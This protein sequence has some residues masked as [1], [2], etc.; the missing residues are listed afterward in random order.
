MLS[1]KPLLTGNGLSAGFSVLMRLAYKA[2]G[3]ALGAV[4]QKGI[5]RI[6]A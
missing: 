2:S 3:A 4:P 1:Q 5:G 6:Y